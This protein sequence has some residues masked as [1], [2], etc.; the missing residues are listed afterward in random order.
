MPSTPVRWY[1]FC[2]A[3]LSYRTYGRSRLTE[4]RVEA[5]GPRVRAA[6]GYVVIRRR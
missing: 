5:A 1:R 2:N 4:A 3:R 6:T